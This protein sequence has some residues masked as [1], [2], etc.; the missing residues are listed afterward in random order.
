[1]PVILVWLN[2][3]KQKSSNEVVV[4]LF[5][6]ALLITGMFAFLSTL[7]QRKASWE[8]TL[9]LKDGRR[10][11]FQAET[12]LKETGMMK[13]L[14]QAGSISRPTLL[15]SAPRSDIRPTKVSTKLTWYEHLWTALPIGL[16]AIGG[17][18]GGVCGFTAWAIN[19]TV[20]KKMENPVLK[21]V[22]TGLIS[23]S[24]VVLWFVV[25]AFFWSRTHGS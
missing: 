10:Y 15:I 7:K 24:A 19:K 1:L 12:A 14:L 11:C 8:Y 20:F 4:V 25:G 3:A 2:L 22:V 9:T 21:Y 5:G 18:I 13:A 17:G 6:G 23:A 16:V